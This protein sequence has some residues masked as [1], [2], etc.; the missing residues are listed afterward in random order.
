M[1]PRIAI[2]LL[3]A[4]G[5]VQLAGILIGARSR[6]G[7]GSVSGSGAG[8][9]TRPEFARLLQARTRPAAPAVSTAFRWAS[10]ESTN[11]FDYVANL[12][13]FGVPEETV[14]DIVVADVNKLYAS[15]E[16]PLKAQ[17]SSPDAT[18]QNTTARR[19]ALEASL[20]A[21]QK[22]RD[23]LREKNELLKALVGVTLPLERPGANPRELERYQSAFNALPS[24]KRDAVREIQENYWLN[25]DALLA[26]A[27]S[28]RSTGFA[29][30]LRKLKADR[31]AQLGKVLTAAELEEFEIRT[32]GVGVGLSE[33]LADFKP[34]EEEFRQIFRIR[35]QLDEADSGRVLG[36]GAARRALGDRERQ[37]D[38]QIKGLL[39]APR[40][41]EYQRSQDPIY[42]ELLPLAARYGLS[43]EA[44]LRGYESLR[45]S[46]EQEEEVRTNRSL[47]QEQRREALTSLQA[48]RDQT[49]SSTFG[50]KAARAFKR[51]ADF[52]FSSPGE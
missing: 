1:K 34:G 13:A 3:L 8:D 32:S 28:R 38:E 18:R 40:Y 35:R 30:A 44:V 31:Q 11:Y 51:S 47:S 10:L 52:L 2:A 50:E 43:K 4:L 49:L 22:L 5:L 6:D 14:R 21:R 27:P 9:L 42:Q 41:A 24:A 37:V 48:R 25:F 23:L 17:L 20:E 15:L 26:S 12:R 33:A 7:A 45:Q 39:G 46:S 36:G 29:E 19:A 16:A